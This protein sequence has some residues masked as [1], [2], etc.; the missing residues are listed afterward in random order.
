MI[1]LIRAMFQ[2]ALKTNDSLFFPVLTGCLRM[3]KE[4]I[5][6][7][8]NNLMAHSIS[9]G[10]QYEL[11]IPN[12]E[13]RQIFK[14][15]APEWF[16]ERAKTETDNISGLYEAFEVGDAETIAS[17]LNRQLITTASFY[18]ARESFYH[19]FLPALLSAGAQW[20]V[21]RNVEIRNG[22]C[23]VIVEREDGQFGFVVELKVIH[24]RA[25]LDNAC[26]AALKQ[27][28]DRDYP[29]LLRR[30]GVEDIRA[31]GVAFCEKRCRVAALHVES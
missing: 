5:F 2:S 1:D 23:D 6:T 15:Q 24:D 4:S 9:F 28:E 8:P 13:V 20:Q 10:R 25:Q 21:P 12:H 29:A 16:S 31:Y 7:G 26:E 18:D 3:S 11:R 27:M 19:G 17:Y 14:Q 22:R 30:F